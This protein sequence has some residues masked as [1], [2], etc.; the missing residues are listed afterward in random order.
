MRQRQRCRSELGSSVYLWSVLNISDR[1]AIIAIVLVCIATIGGLLAAMIWFLCR[2]RRRVKQK[3]AED[4]EDSFLIVSN[5]R[6]SNRRMNGEK[7]FSQTSQDPPSAPPMAVTYFSSLSPIPREPPLTLQMDRR[8]RGSRGSR[9]SEI[10]VSGGE[11]G[12]N[13][14]G[15]SRQSSGFVRDP[16]YTDANLDLLEPTSASWI[17]PRFPSKG[18]A[19]PSLPMSQIPVPLSTPS[20]TYAATNRLPSVMVQRAQTLRSPRSPR[21][22]TD[23]LSSDEIEHILDMATMYGAPTSPMGSARSIAYRDS[24]ISGYGGRSDR[25][26]ENATIASVSSQRMNTFLRPSPASSPVVLTSPSGL[27]TPDTARGPPQVP[28][29]SSPVPSPLTSPT[30]SHF[31]STAT[32]GHSIR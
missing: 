2:E 22:P 1:A 17:S 21:S 8:S 18:R 11:R 12:S 20:P 10:R 26:D 3:Q 6:G 25:A 14:S 31:A 32:L 24:Q 15:Y 29:P 28:L 27:L 5:K 30:G 19:T 9:T 16:L 7:T 23:S 13:Y 4:I